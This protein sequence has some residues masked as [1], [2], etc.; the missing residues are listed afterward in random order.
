MEVRR[1]NDYENEFQTPCGFHAGGSA[2]VCTA[3]GTPRRSGREQFIR[4]GFGF[5]G[6]ALGENR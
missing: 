2:F 1:R 6:S 3:A 4:V 5:K